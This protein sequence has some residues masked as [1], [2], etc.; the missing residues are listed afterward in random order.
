MSHPPAEATDLE[1][2]EAMLRRAGIDYTREIDDRNEPHN[3][4]LPGEILLFVERGYV[5]FVAELRFSPT[6]ALRN[7]SAWE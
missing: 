5:G 1:I 6:G 7:V 4:Y 2:M 3:G